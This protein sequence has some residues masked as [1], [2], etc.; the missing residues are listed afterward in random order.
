M[1]HG[2]NLEKRCLA[3]RYLRLQKNTPAPLA[4][5]ERTMYEV[6]P[7]LTYEDRFNDY[8]ELWT[9]P[10]I[11]EVLAERS[12]KILKL[13]YIDEYS[14]TEIAE[15]YDMTKSRV[16][17]II[18][19]AIEAL[20]YPKIAREILKACGFPDLKLYSVYKWNSYDDPHKW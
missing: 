19:S 15:Q 6:L 4:L 18:Q 1:E 13:Y 16:S 8:E 5:R 14:F 3:C 2:C 17:K 20:H 12:L 10:V 11:K 7:S 9:L